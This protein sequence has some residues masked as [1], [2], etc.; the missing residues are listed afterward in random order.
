MASSCSPLE[1]SSKLA[2]VFSFGKNMG[3]LGERLKLPENPPSDLAE[4]SNHQFYFSKIGQR[5]TGKGGVHLSYGDTVHGL[6]QTISRD[7][8][9]LLDLYEAAPYAYRREELT[10]F[11]P[12][13]KA[14]FTAVTYIPIQDYTLTTVE[15]TPFNLCP[16][17]SYYQDVIKGARDAKLPE[18]AIDAINN[19]YRKSIPCPDFSNQ[20]LKDQIE[21]FHAKREDFESPIPSLP[22]KQVVKLYD[23]LDKEHQNEYT[24]NPLEPTEGMWHKREKP[25]RH[26]VK[27]E[28]P[29][30]FCHPDLLEYLKR[31]VES[32]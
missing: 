19:A 32:T 14:N 30:I 22:S 10:V 23:V 17:R 27:K 29:C 18:K 31:E 21:A 1:S 12:S 24:R 11:V 5:G 25:L 16:S 20:T 6:V 7:H 28:D 13:K 3:S 26:F 15:G 2:S 9:P 8:L 4:L